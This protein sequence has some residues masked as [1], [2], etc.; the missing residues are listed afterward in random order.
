[1]KYK[2]GDKVELKDGQSSIIIKYAKSVDDTEGY[3]IE[4]MILKTNDDIV[5]KIEN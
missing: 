3:F 5:R 2:V 1:M 4:G